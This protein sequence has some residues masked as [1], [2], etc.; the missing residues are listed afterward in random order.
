MLILLARPLLQFS[1][2]LRLPVNVRVCVCGCVCVFRFGLVMFSQCFFACAAVDSK[3][4][5]VGWGRHG[6][7]PFCLWCSIVTGVS[8][9][10]T[11]VDE[12]CCCGDRS[13]CYRCVFFLRRG[14]TG[15]GK[16]DC[17]FIYLF[18]LSSILSFLLYNNMHYLATIAHTHARS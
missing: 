7:R 18:L 1:P 3:G 11:V 8:F 2:I 6:Y 9:F 10:D 13:R 4:I 15:Q 12:R 14:G 17:C 16:Q 5:C